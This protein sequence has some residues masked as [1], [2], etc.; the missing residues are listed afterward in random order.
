MTAQHRTATGL[1]H[2]LTAALVV[3]G[4]CFIASAQHPQVLS[5]LAPHLIA[6]TL[7]HLGVHV[8]GLP[9][10]ALLVPLGNGVDG[11]LKGVCL[12]DEACLIDALSRTELHQTILRVGVGRAAGVRM[13]LIKLQAG[14]AGTGRFSIG[15]MHEDVARALGAAFASTL[16]LEHVDVWAVVPGGELIGDEQEHFPVFSV[17]VSRSVFERADATAQTPG[18]LIAG[19]DVVRYSPL[20]LDYADDAGQVRLPRSGLSDPELSGVWDLLVAQGMG[21]EARAQIRAVERVT[22]IFSGARHGREVALT[23]DDGPHPLITPLMLRLLQREGVKAT[24]FVVGGKCEEFPGLVRMIAAGG[25]ELANHAY[26]NRRLSDLPTEQAWAEVAACDRIIKRITGRQ[27]SYF[28]PPGGRCSPHG[29]RAVAAL[30]YTIALWS[31]NTGDWRKPPPEVIRQNA[32]AGLRAGD[33]IL[34]HQGEMCSVEALPGI[35]AG[36]RAAGLEPVTLAQLGGNGGVVSDTPERVSVT[37][38]DGMLGEE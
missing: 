16:R 32:L 12:S 17:S 11:V 21:T 22:A 6:D 38:N 15:R 20:L 25:H 5:H 14:D 3:S 37:V 2:L 36:V 4:G 18:D 13:A 23:I 10:P 33:I 30:G 1:T 19:L 9:P 31:R 35:I 26:S 34:M 29:L 7:S 28:R 27:M 8:P 24:F